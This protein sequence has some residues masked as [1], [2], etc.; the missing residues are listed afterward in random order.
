MAF[1]PQLTPFY[2]NQGFRPQATQNLGFGMQSTGNPYADLY[3]QWVNQQLAP[4]QK[5]FPQPTSQPAQIPGI[6]QDPQIQSYLQ[7]LKRNMQSSQW[8]SGGNP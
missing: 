2:G 3:T 1:V 5:Q 4:Y 6:L 7:D 8:R